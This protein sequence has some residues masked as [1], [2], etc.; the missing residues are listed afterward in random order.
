MTSIASMIE[1]PDSNQKNDLMP[2]GLLKS[3]SPCRVAWKVCHYLARFAGSVFFPY[4]RV[5]GET[6]QKL[7]GQIFIARNYGLL[8]WLTVLRMFKRP[9]RIVLVDAAADLRWLNLAQKS[10]LAPLKL[11]DA[12]AEN[13]LTV[14]HLAEAGERLLLIVPQVSSPAIDSLISQLRAIHSLKV[15]FMAISGA[16]EALP[17]GAFVPRAVPISV[18]CGLPH[19]PGD[20][21]LS[22]LAELDFLEQAIK[23]L[24]IDELPSI[25]FNHPRNLSNIR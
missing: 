6:D 8:T 2:G 18:F 25:F 14:E 11:D 22:P 23:D 16:R 7:G 13:F 12:P 24:E 1:S 3:E 21:A 19:Y 10:G 15:L 4:F 20:P 17:T 5:W 9:I